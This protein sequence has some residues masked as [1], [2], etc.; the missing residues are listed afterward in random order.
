MLT[1]IFLIAAT[2][3]RINPCAATILEVATA[4]DDSCGAGV[5]GNCAVSALQKAKAQ[6][7]IPPVCSLQKDSPELDLPIAKAGAQNPN[8]LNEARC[9][10]GQ[11][12][13]STACA[14]ANAKKDFSLYTAF[15]GQ[16]KES[17]QTHSLTVK[18]DNHTIITRHKDAVND[19]I[20]DAMEWLDVAGRKDDAMYMGS[21]K[22]LMKNFANWKWVANLECTNL[23]KT[24]PDMKDMSFKQV[25]SMLNNFGPPSK[26]SKLWTTD[27]NS[28]TLRRLAAAKCLVGEAGCQMAHCTVNVCKDTKEDPVFHHGAARCQQLRHSSLLNLNNATKQQDVPKSHQN[29][30]AQPHL[31]EL[32]TAGMKSW[33]AFSKA[34]MLVRE[35]SRHQAEIQNLISSAVN[36][37]QKMIA[38]ASEALQS[39]DGLS[40]IGYMMGCSKRFTASET[41]QKLSVLLSGKDKNSERACFVAN[42]SPNHYACAAAR[43]NHNYTKYVQHM[44]GPIKMSPLS[45]ES[46][47]VTYNKG[48]QTLYTTLHEKALADVFCS[49]TGWV[50]LPKRLVRNSRAWERIEQRQCRRLLAAHPEAKSMSLFEVDQEHKKLA[51]EGFRT[52]EEWRSNA[53][54]HI[55]RRHAAVQCLLGTAGCNMANCAANYCLQEN[56]QG[57][58]FMG[59][60]EDCPSVG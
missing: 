27:A 50:S 47:K 30:T 4:L 26:S 28:T 53:T 42:L 12:Y 35:A 33:S 56:K 46:L 52:K 21:A 3:T 60:G 41:E 59:H 23:M 49:A 57:N 45:I 20:C 55:M 18:Y 8:F 16:D 17:E 14:E 6:Y 2:V 22:D 25:V 51:K 9:L 31:A 54:V 48:H 58:K 36:A 1:I 39:K 11:M 29:I 32:S 37:S 44:R 24:Y 13:S 5:D 40:T 19:M 7:P 15:S 10:Y 43:H 38:T 34:A